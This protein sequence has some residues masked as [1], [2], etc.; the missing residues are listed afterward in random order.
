[1][2]NVIFW[3]LTPCGHVSK[4]RVASIIRVSR[5]T[6]S[7]MMEA[8]RSSETPNLTRVTRRNI[9]ED[10]NVHSHRPSN[11]KSYIALTGWDL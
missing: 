2:K 9:Q 8:T 1:M 6:V 3:D 11:L 5:I 7:L 4:E 10:D